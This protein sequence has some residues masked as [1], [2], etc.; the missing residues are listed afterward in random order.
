[1]ILCGRIFVNNLKEF[2]Y[3]KNELYFEGGYDEVTGKRGSSGLWKISWLDKM[4][5]MSIK[6]PPETRKCFEII[7]EHK[8]KMI[9]NFDVQKKRTHSLNHLNIDLTQSINLLLLCS[10]CPEQRS[11]CSSCEEWKMKEINAVNHLKQTGSQVLVV[12]YNS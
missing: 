2:F 6:R 5:N 3:L 11:L 8:K 1:M 10:P 4:T 7:F 12:L 9:F